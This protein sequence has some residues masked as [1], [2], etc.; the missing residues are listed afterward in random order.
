VAIPEQQLETWTGLGSVQQSASTYQ[1]I[2]GVIENSD[3][4]YAGKQ[5]K[6]FLQGSYCND[7]N[8]Y[9]DS[10]VD[11]VLR[12]RAL[13]HYNIQ[14][15]PEPQNSLFKQEHPNVAP[16][17]L[18]DFRKD[19]VTWLTDKFGGDLD[20]SSKKALK[21][22]AN[23]NRRNADILLAA[24][25]K[26]YTRYVGR[27][28]EDQ[29]FIEGVLFITTDN[30]EIINYP[31]QHSANLTAKHQ[32]TGNLLKPTIRVYKNIRNKMVER[33]LI[34]AGTAP[35]YF[36]E[37]ML[38]NVP[39][40]HFTTNR[41]KTVEACWGW[42]NTTD[43]AALMCANGIHP[44]SRDNTDTSWPIQGYIDFLKGVRDLWTQW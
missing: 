16:Y 10:D 15:L 34:K 17:K 5:V 3:A 40:E 4:P 37:G 19:V 32:A 41:Q 27:R 11:I 13:F 7:T 21:I 20:T 24:P 33:G 29:T 18:P 38:S 8:I 14:S 43:H 36:I 44:L 31:E 35:S 22:K 42:I 2:K 23:G 1:T 28:P 30:R 25:H 9:G 26:K 6:S 12:T 39:K